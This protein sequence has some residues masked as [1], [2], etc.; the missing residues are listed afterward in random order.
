MSA[1]RYVVLHH[2]GIDR[3][4]YDLMFERNPHEAL[5]TVRCS[6]WPPADGTVFERIGDH[7]RS[8]LDYEGP[9]S[10]NRG[11]VARIEAGV[12]SVEPDRV[13]SLILLLSSGIQIRIPNAGWHKT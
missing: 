12:Y 3:P 7:R 2:T 4:H 6:D 13:D 1:L 10:G 9:V 5:A 11:D 8:Y